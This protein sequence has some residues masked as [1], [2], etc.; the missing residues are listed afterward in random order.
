M[1]FVK[2]R[3]FAGHWH[4]GG[5]MGLHLGLYERPR[6]LTRVMCKWLLQWEWRD[7]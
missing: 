3:P 1:S 7:S 2:L 6:W 4:I 5:E